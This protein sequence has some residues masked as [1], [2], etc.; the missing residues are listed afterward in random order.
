[1]IPSPLPAL[2]NANAVT[3]KFI[4]ELIVRAYRRFLPGGKTTKT[5]RIAELIE[6]RAWTAVALALIDLEPP[7]WQIRRIAYDSG[8][9]HCALSHQRELTDWL[10]DPIEARHA[11]LA[12]ALL[13]AGAA[14]RVP[15][16]RQAADDPC[17]PI[18]RDNFR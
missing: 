7:L 3:P 10:D 2:G 18:C 4:A 16:V 8:D 12:L 14:S 15:L 11:H 9:W 6:A 13:G 17:K 5:A 1:M